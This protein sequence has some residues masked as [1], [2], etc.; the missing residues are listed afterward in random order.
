MNNLE[1][2]QAIKESNRRHY[3]IAKF[4]NISENTFSRRLRYELPQEEK[5]KILKIIKDNRKEN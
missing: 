3:E 2:R 1:I 5:E 4:M